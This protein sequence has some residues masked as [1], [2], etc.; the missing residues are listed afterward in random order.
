MRFNVLDL[1]RFSAAMTVVLYHYT[2]GESS[3]L[4]W[5]I[6]EFTKFGYL[7]VPLFFMIS[8][9]VI[10]AS[11][12]NRTPAE[13]A[14][15]RATRLYPTVFVC[16]TVTVLIVQ[17]LTFGQNEISLLQYL[18]NLTILNTYVGQDYVDSVYWTLL[19]ELKF[20]LCVF[21][22]LAIG[23]FDK[24]KIWLS[25]WMLMTITFL[26][27]EQPFFMGWFISPEYS[28]FFIA[29]VSFFLVTKNGYSTYYSG[30]LIAS[31]VV[32]SIRVYQQASGFMHGADQLDHL[33]SLCFVWSFFY[34][35]YMISLDK[36][37]I[38]P[39]KT[40]L[41]LGGMTYPL[42][43]L[44]SR[45]GEIVL[46]GL[47]L[48]LGLDPYVSLLLTIALVLSMAYLVHVYV[49]KGAANAIKNYL[50]DSLNRIRENPGRE[51]LINSLFHI[52]GK[53]DQDPNIRH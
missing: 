6:S 16:L 39:S 32:G 1:M 2:S 46:P 37:Q 40:F 42:Y 29:G 19:A 20:Y 15:S 23:L 47:G 35:F 3:E 24:F 11:A 5:L 12:L 22:L 34:L 4:F 44:H 28:A 45:I 41:L 36:I 51:N 26:L 48:G 25:A 9:F 33:I 31:L 50:F 43:L 10:S 30:L 27:F 21:L 13:F 52:S 38:K 49:E 14:I 17:T 8:G 18:T 7:G 53:Q